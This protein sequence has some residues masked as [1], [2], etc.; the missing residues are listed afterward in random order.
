MVYAIAS[1][2]AALVDAE[3][4]EKRIDRLGSYLEQ[5]EKIEAAGHDAYRA[6]S[7][8]RSAAERLV[9]ISIQICIDIAAHLIAERGPKMPDDYRGVFAALSPGLD[10]ELAERL[11]NAVGMRNVLVH[12]YLEVDDELVWDAIAHLDDLRQFAAFAARQLD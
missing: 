7:Q 5:L 4:I 2:R 10:P 6:D 11:A 12:G 3:S 9:Q 8:A 1:R